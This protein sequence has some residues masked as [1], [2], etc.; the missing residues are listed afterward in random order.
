[1]E[2]PALS[3]IRPFLGGVVRT[4][5]Q[6]PGSG[7]YQERGR[8]ETGGGRWVACILQAGQGQQPPRVQ[9]PHLSSRAFET[10][11]ETSNFNDPQLVTSKKREAEAPSHLL[12]TGA[13]SLDIKC[14]GN[15]TGFP[16]LHFIRPRVWT[17]VGSRFRY[18]FFKVSFID[19]M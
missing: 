18:V 5:T 1:M 13:V 17:H 3:S 7:D 9:S 15:T 4:N 8:R 16:R 6:S 2:A 14:W 19:I 10:Q 11:R 12:L